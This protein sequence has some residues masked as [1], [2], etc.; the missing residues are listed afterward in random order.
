MQHNDSIQAKIMRKQ[1]FCLNLANNFSKQLSAKKLL[2]ILNKAAEMFEQSGIYLKA[3]ECYEYEKDWDGLLMCLS[4]NKSKFLKI[5]RDS[6]I[7]R[8]VPI[9]LN[10]I[11]QLLNERGVDEDNKGKLLQEKYEK[12]KIEIIKEESDYSESESEEE[13]KEEESQGKSI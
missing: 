3:F 5:E 4:R 12:S 10:S 11:Y 13:K 8:Y 9:A 2:G 1:E 7:N 6:L